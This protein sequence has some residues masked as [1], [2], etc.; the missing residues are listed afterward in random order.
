MKI[1]QGKIATVRSGEVAFISG[2]VW[3]RP[4]VWSGACVFERI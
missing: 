2:E 3:G 1:T 4:S